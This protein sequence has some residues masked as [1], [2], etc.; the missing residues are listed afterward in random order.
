M[1]II[2]F[3][4]AVASLNCRK[5]GGRSGLPTLEEVHQFLEMFPSKDS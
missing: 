3:A 5:L 2:R 4:S 1:E